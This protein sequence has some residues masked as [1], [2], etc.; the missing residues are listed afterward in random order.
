MRAEMYCLGLLEQVAALLKDAELDPAERVPDALRALRILA[1]GASQRARQPDVLLALCRRIGR[2]SD[3]AP[4]EV[5]ESHGV[6]NPVA[7]SDELDQSP[8]VVRAR[9]CEVRRV[10]SEK[11]AL[12]SE[13]WRALDLQ[14]S[15]RFAQLSPS[16]SVSGRSSARPV[17]VVPPAR[18]RRFAVEREIPSEGFKRPSMV[19]VALALHGAESK[20]GRG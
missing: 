20:R 19:A 16:L 15:K 7:D 10:V 12:L 6:Y 3:T 8:R 9:L 17:A 5:G 1:A 13:A 4:N 11:S 2:H 18:G 14:L